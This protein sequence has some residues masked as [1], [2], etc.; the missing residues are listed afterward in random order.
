MGNLCSNLCNGPKNSEK[1]ENQNGG[2]SGNNIPYSFPSNNNIQNNNLQT[3]TD[4]KNNKQNAISNLYDPNLGT[5]IESSNNQTPNPTKKTDIGNS[6]NPNMICIDVNSSIKGGFKQNINCIVHSSILYGFVPIKEDNTNINTNSVSDMF[7]PGFASFIPHLYSVSINDL[8]MK[9]VDNGNKPTSTSTPNKDINGDYGYDCNDKNTTK[10]DDTALIAQKIQT[11][12]QVLDPNINY[13]KS[14]KFESEIFGAIISKFINRKDADNKIL[15]PRHQIVES[16]E[17]FD[18]SIKDDNQVLQCSDIN[19]ENPI[20]DSNKTNNW[21]INSFMP[22]S[23][24]KFDSLISN[25]SILFI[26]NNQTCETLI[27]ELFASNKTFNDPDFPPNFNSLWGFGEATN[28]SESNWKKYEWKRPIDFFEGPYKIYENKFE[29]ND[30][31]QGELGDCYFLSAIAAVAEWKDR[32]KKLFLTRECNEQNVFCVGLCINGMWEEVIVDDYFPVS[33]KK[34]AMPKY[35]PSFNHSKGNELWVMILE[36]AWAKVHGGYLNIN[37]GLVRE[38]LHDLT[39]APCSTYFN[40]EY[41]DEERWQIILDAFKRNYIMAASTKDLEGNGKDYMEK[42]SGIVGNHSYSLLEAIEIVKDENGDWCRIKYDENAEQIQGVTKLIKLRN[43]WGKGEWKGAF[44][45]N[46]SKMNDQLKNVLNHKN[47]VDG[48]FYMPFDEFIR[49]FSDF[50]ICYYIDSYKYSSTR[51]ETEN[52]MHCYFTFSVKAEGEYYFTLNQ[53]NKRFFPKKNNYKYSSCMFTLGRLEDDDGITYLGAMQKADKESWF[54]AYCTK[55]VY[56]ISVYTPWK[57]FVNQ[58][59]IAS[60]GPETIH[61]KLLP[62]DQLPVNYYK[63]LVEN[64]A[65]KSLSPWKD[66][67]RLGYANIRY[68]F[69]HGNDG[70]GYF[71]FEN[72]SLDTEFKCELDFTETSNIKAQYPYTL[73][74][75]CIIVPAQSKEF[76]IYFMTDTPSKVAFKMLASFQKNVLALKKEVKT[77]GVKIPRE[78]NDEDVGIHLYGLMHESGCIWEYENLSAEY[79]LEETIK[80][81]LV[82]AWIDGYDGDSIKIVLNPGQKKLIEIIYGKGNNEDSGNLEECTFRITKVA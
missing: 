9:K 13:K 2:G 73:D 29:P 76:L 79:M 11:N 46:D 49:Y 54:K 44:S 25:K 8:P 42:K 47:E 1:K 39:G 60:Y 61:L 71:Y 81:K 51:Q 58:I 62:N 23:A 52:N 78:L 30:I 27:M 77:K 26:G 16:E 21:V 75:P 15:L 14:E 22:K 57:S 12:S 34:N 3:G 40:D 19:T 65:Q 7:Q 74:S 70:F 48:C 17:D 33:Y 36:K 43:P 20:I 18:G 69:E 68:K 63:K 56:F 72:K 50:Q 10:L 55:G 28:F 45:D 82:N 64:K 37:N 6:Y 35:N 4:I 31:Q 5:V 66:F 80:V 67:D 32:V 53:Q 38:A 24:Q 41:S 59:T